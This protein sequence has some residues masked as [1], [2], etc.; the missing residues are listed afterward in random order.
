ML[1]ENTVSI[2]KEIK[3]LDI[4]EGELKLYLYINRIRYSN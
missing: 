3:D 1:D 2:V 4:I